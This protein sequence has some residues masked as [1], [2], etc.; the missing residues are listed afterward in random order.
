MSVNKAPIF[1]RLTRISRLAVW[2]VKTCRN[3]SRLNGCNEMQRNEALLHLGRSALTALDIRIESSGLKEGLVE[4][5]VLVVS[6]HVSWL[7]IFA[8]SAVY[9]SSFIAKKEISSWPV[10]GKMGRNAGTIFINRNSRKDVE[11]INQAITAA[12]KNGQNVSFFPEAKTSSGETV[13]P[14][15]A[16]LFQSAIDASAP[17]QAVA[18]RYYDCSGRRTA[19][20]SYAGKANLFATLWRIVSLN[21]LTVKMDF[22]PL[23]HTLENNGLDRYELKDLAENFVQQKVLED[24]PAVEN[25]N[26]RLGVNI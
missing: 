18:L 13:L 6:N 9:P 14:F 24:S 1:I 22:A 15:K 7:D 23:I 2:L 10:F 26:N 4:S 20:P 17:V 3:L 19:E 25:G 21:E 12:L 8:M 5:G 11:P 16:A